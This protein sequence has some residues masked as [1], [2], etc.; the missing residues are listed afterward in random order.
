LA[1][2]SETADSIAELF[3][4]NSF[5]LSYFGNGTFVTVANQMQDIASDDFEHATDHALNRRLSAL[6]DQLG[7]AFHVSVG[8]SIQ[9][10]ARANDRAEA[11][12]QNAIG[13]V[14]MRFASQSAQA[15]A[16]RLRLLG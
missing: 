12:I 7:I 5:I 3:A 11:A 8:A 10:H 1:L 6:G 4:S 14:E 2:L 13:A 16:P 9:P 15:D